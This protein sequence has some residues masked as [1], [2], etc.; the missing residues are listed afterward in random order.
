MDKVLNPFSLQSLSKRLPVLAVLHINKDLVPPN[1]ARQQSS[2]A[3]APAVEQS[4]FL[5]S[6]LQAASVQLWTNRISFT[7]TLLHLKHTTLSVF[8]IW[9]SGGNTVSNLFSLSLSL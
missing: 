1:F 3:S 7:E 9:F 6:H 5:A 8:H 2:G 4:A